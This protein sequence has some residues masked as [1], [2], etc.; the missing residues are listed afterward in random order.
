MRNKLT[1]IEPK[2]IQ[3]PNPLI[4]HQRLLITH[5]VLLVLLALTVD[6]II[7]PRPTF[8]IRPDD[9]IPL[10]LLELDQILVM[11]LPIG[12]DAGE[13]VLAFLGDEGARTHGIKVEAEGVE[14]GEAGYGKAF[15]AYLVV[16]LALSA[17]P[18]AELLVLEK[19]DALVHTSKIMIFHTPII[20][21]HCL[22]LI[23]ATHL[24]MVTRSH[25]TNQTIPMLSLILLQHTKL[26]IP[27][28]LKPTIVVISSIARI[29][30][31]KVKF[32]L[33]QLVNPSRSQCGMLDTLEFLVLF[34]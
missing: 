4:I 33:L 27:L 9:D 20:H 13:H 31:R 8:G 22:F 32:Q 2:F 30:G 11:L 7:Q 25:T 6:P 14:L 24:D 10:F 23:L 12:I 28:L 18:V 29:H 3:L 5:L 15:A 19:E 1:P 34:S 26:L 16:E 17:D 21:R